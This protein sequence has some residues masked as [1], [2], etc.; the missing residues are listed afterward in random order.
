MIRFDDLTKSESENL[1]VETRIIC[2]CCHMGFISVDDEMDNRFVFPNDKRKFVVPMNYP[3]CSR[4]NTKFEVVIDKT[5]KITM[6]KI[7]S[8]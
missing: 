3:T 7:K 6:R 4:C 1:K 5:L 2:P 8:Y